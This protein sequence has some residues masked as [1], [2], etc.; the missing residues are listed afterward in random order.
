MPLE[1][2]P[3]CGYALS[4]VNHHCRHCGTASR[5][6]PSRPI[7]AKYLQQKI[8]MAVVALSVLVYL[9]FFR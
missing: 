6:I 9:M 5:A 2:C 1:P 3:T 8:I 4:T 7:N